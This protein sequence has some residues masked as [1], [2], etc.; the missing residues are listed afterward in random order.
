M[1]PLPE[2]LVCLSVDVEW[3][4]ADVLADLVRLLDEHRVRATF[5]CT[6]ALIEVGAHERGLHP[7]FRRNGDTLR[8]L[9]D[10]LNDRDVYRHAVRAT[11]EFCPGAIGVR[12]H[13]LHYDTQL[14]EIYSA[15]GLQYDSSYCAS[16]VENL[17]PF[18]KEHNLLEIPIYYMDHLDL[19]DQATGFTVSGL[20]LQRPG[21]KVFDFH[22]NLVFINAHTC[23]HYEHSKSFYGDPERLLAARHPGRGIRTLLLELLAWLRR[24]GVPT[25]TLG[26]V[27][28]L[29]RT[30]G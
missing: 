26:E 30:G 9:P 3:A 15:E 25:A 23:A 17:R 7:N 14:T 6:H 27:N 19:M 2:N 10:G 24:T 18:R 28:Q 16:L 11:K 21:L 5:F 12:A 29:W 1:G 22:P 20:Q 13:S 8:A 4:H